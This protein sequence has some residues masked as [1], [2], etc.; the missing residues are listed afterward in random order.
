MSEWRERAT[1][2]RLFVEGTAARVCSVAPYQVR[3]VAVRYAD[4]APAQLE[5]LARLGSLHVRRSG[6]KRF[7]RLHDQGASASVLDGLLH[8]GDLLR[9]HTEP[10]RFPACTGTCWHERVRFVDPRFV[11]VEKPAGLPCSPHVSNAAHV[12][13]RCI[14]EDFLGPK[15][16][17][18]ERTTGEM[19]AE[20]SSVRDLIPLH[21]LDICTTGLVALARTKAAARDFATVQ[22]LDRRG[23]ADEGAAAHRQGNS[24]E[25]YLK[26]YRACFLAPTC[27]PVA[28]ERLLAAAS[29]PTQHSRHGE[30]G[31]EDRPEVKV[32]SWISSPMFEMPAPRF[33]SSCPVPDNGLRF[34]QHGREVGQGRGTWKYAVTGVISWKRISGRLSSTHPTQP[35]CPAEAPGASAAALR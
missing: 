35:P 12:L 13:H 3:D 25:G 9:I 22:E 28:L 21:R 27:G 30:E 18:K 16:N 7:T 8:T 17:R 4:I 34:G 11:V 5:E 19:P 26:I 31:E 15:E 32:E 1:P 29:G 24:A 20:I 2:P 14:L 10:V 23:F 33:I 6:N